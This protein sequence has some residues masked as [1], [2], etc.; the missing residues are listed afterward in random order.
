MF[1]SLIF[2]SCPPSHRFLFRTLFSFRAAVA[3]THRT[4]TKKTHQKTPPARQVIILSDYKSN[5]NNYLRSKFRVRPDRP[6]PQG[7]EKFTRP[8]PNPPLHSTPSYLRVWMNWTP[9]A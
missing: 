3:L 4:T 2:P 6:R 8:P 1:F 5:I 9:V 7:Q